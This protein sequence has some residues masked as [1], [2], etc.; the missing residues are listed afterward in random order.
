MLEAAASLRYVSF[1]IIMMVH[2]DAADIFSFCSTFLQ[3]DVGKTLILCD[4]VIC[5]REL[6]SLTCGLAR[7]SDVA[8]LIIYWNE[9]HTKLSYLLTPFYN[10]CVPINMKMALT[11]PENNLTLKSSFFLTNSN[12]FLFLLW[13]NLNRFIC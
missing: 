11:A 12:T 7:L 2:T 1:T 6:D 10:L 4:L 9:L 5:Q 8:S 13:C 3:L